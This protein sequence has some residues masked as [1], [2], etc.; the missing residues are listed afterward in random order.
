MTDC[1]FCK[2]VA[3]EIPATI[4][5]ETERSLAFKDINAAAPIHALVIPKDHIASLADLGPSQG[6]LL[7][8]LFG[9]VTSVAEASD[10]AH[11]YRVVTNVGQ[12]G[13]QAVDHLHFHL[14][15]GRGL[16]WPPG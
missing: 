9:L 8:D 7:E 6:E 4:V 13:G 3:R 11:G 14:L 16:S 5:G 15:G 1:L 12:D 10:L 2:I